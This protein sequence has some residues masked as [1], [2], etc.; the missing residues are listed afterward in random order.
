[1][2]WNVPIVK[3]NSFAT[4]QSIED[5]VLAVAVAVDQP[6]AREDLGQ[7]LELE[8]APRRHA[9]AA[10]VFERAPTPPRTRARR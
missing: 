7:R 2:C 10:A 3:P 1:M 4:R 8:V 6:L 9:L 5:L